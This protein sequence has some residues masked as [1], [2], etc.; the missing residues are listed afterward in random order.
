MKEYLI[1]EK[2]LPISPAPKIP[3]N[4]ILVAFF[5]V[6]I[7]DRLALTHIENLVH[8]T[9]NTKTNIKFT[10]RLTSVLIK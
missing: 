1:K 4:P 3:N 7:L 9:H 6:E 10:T 8:G 5:A 2:F